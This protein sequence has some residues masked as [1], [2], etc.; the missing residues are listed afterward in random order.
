MVRKLSLFLTSLCFTP[1]LPFPHRRQQII[2]FLEELAEELPASPGCEDVLQIWLE[3]FGTGGL[4]LGNLGLFLLGF[5][6]MIL[7]DIFLHRCSRPAICLLVRSVSGLYCLL[8]FR[9]HNPAVRLMMVLFCLYWL[10]CGFWWSIGFLFLVY[11]T[12]MG[13]RYARGGRLC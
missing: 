2:D 9:N 10:I 8:K 12:N 4:L 11:F 7:S 3:V 13:V 1:T 5:G 6:L